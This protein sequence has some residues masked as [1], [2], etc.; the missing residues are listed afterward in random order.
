MVHNTHTTLAGPLHPISQRHVSDALRTSKN[1][2]PYTLLY[3]TLFHRTRPIGP[4]I[5]EEA[6]CAS[7]GMDIAVGPDNTIWFAIKDKLVSMNDKGKFRTFDIPP[8]GP[9][10]NEVIGITAGKDGNVW[11]AQ[12]YNN[13]IGRMTPQGKCTIFPI[14]TTD[15]RPWYVTAGADGNIWFNERTAH[16]IGRITPEGNI[17]EFALKTPN[18]QASA[19]RSGP[20]GDVWFVEN[21]AA[22]KVGRIT[23]NGAMF[24]DVIAPNAAGFTDIV[25][26]KDGSLW[27]AMCAG[28]GTW[29]RSKQGEVKQFDTPDVEP[30]R[31]TPDK[32]GN[33]WFT[34]MIVKNN[35]IGRLTPEGDITYYKCPTANCA[36][37][38]ITTGTDGNIWFTEGWGKGIGRVNIA[39]VGGDQASGAG[40]PHAK[41]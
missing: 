5:I 22:S 32:Y 39:R 16:K 38:G 28:H 10:G 30:Y 15:A 20:D 31:L 9:L 19:L 2:T 13:A 6:P 23:P 26:T 14:P 34:N 24:E 25:F 35:Q 36:P 17:T 41:P 18:V 29:R 12:L 8:G 33:I 27:C 11:F 37:S 21:G 40:D 7:S 1:G 4:P 3:S